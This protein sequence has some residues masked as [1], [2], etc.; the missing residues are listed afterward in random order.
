VAHF[1][2]SFSFYKDCFPC[3]HNYSLGLC[4]SHASG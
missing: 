4:I 1:T 3:I 2:S